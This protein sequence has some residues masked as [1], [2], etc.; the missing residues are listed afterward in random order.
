MLRLERINSSNVW[1]FVNLQ[2]YSNQQEYV[3]TNAQ[4]II[5][6]YTTIIE[7]G[8]A[9]PFGIYD[10]NTPVGFL[11]I[12]YGADDNKEYEVPIAKN[13]YELWR[14]MID[15]KYQRKGYGK[16][17]IELVIDYVKKFPCGK[18]EYLYLSYEPENEIGKRLYNSLGF[19]ENGMKDEDEIIAVLKL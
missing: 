12:G 13:N 5:E 9:L 15:K 19:K 6:A 11:M 4:S 7:G 17:A 16:K 3:A 10:D 8:V 14:L 2:V 1:S 18:A